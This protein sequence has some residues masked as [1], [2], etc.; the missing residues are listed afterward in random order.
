VITARL[1]RPDVADLLTA[2]RPEL[3]ELNDRAAVIRAKIKRLEVDYAEGEISARI[4]REQTARQQAELDGID[5]RL[6]ALARESR[7]AAVVGAPDPAAA[8]LGLDLGARRAV[9]DALCTVVLLPG[10][11]GRAAFDP[12]T[13]R[14]D[15]RA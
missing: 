5:R 4:L 13:I 10:R 3:A 15:P 12:N 11:P 9:I 6:A 2:E 8:F 7:L 1:R 14:L